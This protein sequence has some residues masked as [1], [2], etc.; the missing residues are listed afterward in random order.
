[1]KP[2][3]KKLFRGVLALILAF[4]VVVLADREHRL[5]SLVQ[6]LEG[7]PIRFHSFNLIIMGVLAGIG[8]VLAKRKGR[9][10]WK[11]LLACFVFH[12]VGLIYLWSL[13]DLRNR[14]GGDF[15]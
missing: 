7:D 10:P 15:P 8:A 3:W 5:M 12:I 14:Q 4:V 11:W 6:W 2:D 13:P 9:H 1:M